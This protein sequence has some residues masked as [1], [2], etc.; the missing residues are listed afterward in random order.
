M[1]RGAQFCNVG[2]QKKKFKLDL[3]MQWITYTF[4]L[5]SRALPCF[6]MLFQLKTP[7]ELTSTSDM[8]CELRVPVLLESKPTRSLLGTPPGWE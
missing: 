4:Q 2:A 1:D 3:H 8:Q 5:I 6:D 7:H